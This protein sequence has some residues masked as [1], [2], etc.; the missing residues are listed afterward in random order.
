MA[1]SAC[2]LFILDMTL[3][4]RRM[5]TLPRNKWRMLADQSKSCVLVLGGDINI[6]GIHT[7]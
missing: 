4:V 2:F 6:V 7:V 1:I 3:T 5:I